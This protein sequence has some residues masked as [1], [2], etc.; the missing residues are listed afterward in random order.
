[1]RVALYARVSTERQEQL[2]TIASQL[3]ALRD[4]AA[5]D[6]VEVIEEFV[7]AG[8]SGARLDRPALDRLR[9]AAQAGLFEQVLVLAAD[10]LARSY[11][12]QVLI[13]EEFERFGVKV[14][15]L[16]GPALT[17]DPQA[18]L[19]VQMQGVIAEYERAKISERYRRGKLH[20]ARQGD[21]FFWKVPYGYRRIPGG[22]GRPNRLEVLESEASVV[23]EIFHAHVN[24]D[25]T[26]RQISLRL[27]AR[28]TP[29]PTGKLTWGSSTMSRLIRNEAY[30][31]TIYYNR[32]ESIHTP[33]P[34]RG[35]HSIKTTY[36][37][38]PKEEWIPITIPAIIDKDLFERAQRINREHL[39]FNP[40]G[41]KPGRFLLRGLVQ[42]GRCHVGCSCHQMRGRNGT[43][44]HYYYCR[45][46]S[47]INAGGQQHRCPER[48]IR[49]NELDN[50]V[51]E[52]VKRAL[53]NPRQLTAG[54]HELSLH[55]PQSDH[56][57]I[58]EQLTRLERRLAHAQ[59]ER[60]RLIDAYQANLID[61]NDLTRRSASITARHHELT[62]EHD[63]LQ[64]RQH[65]LTQ[66]ERLHHA[67]ATFAQKVTE[68]IDDLD[69]DA[70][71]KLLRLAIE[72]VTVTGWRV[73][74]HL[75]IPLTTNQ[76]P[77]T[78]DPSNDMRLYSTDQHRQP[79]LP[80]Q[81]H[82]S[83]DQQPM[84][85]TNRGNLAVPQ[86]REGGWPLTEGEGT[87][88]AASSRNARA[89]TRT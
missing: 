79:I 6:D 70:R 13:L 24:D 52:E 81:E 77:P 57:L 42:C 39:K 16:E 87:G 12:Y 22:D 88:R 47:L 32:R 19:L 69:F 28:G 55:T 75:K 89:Y 10:R 50:F 74:I 73:E 5:R 35:R 68:S 66:Q 36:R 4:A 14:R 2:G 9:D 72:K 76:P 56:N 84:N 38:R 49:S 58:A 23:R 21:P 44:H 48:N 61:L 59:Q 8:H 71:Q 34:T 60:T 15:F 27:Y 17:D 78:N 26:L 7:D 40:R 64:R 54:E 46:H 20:K 63:A 18:R 83:P 29:S 31:G 30:I 37:D 33:N 80:P 65:D 25:L 86:L 11:A 43:H 1:V 3:E 67:I 85:P 45:N 53:L 41:A 82:G 62:Q 51:F